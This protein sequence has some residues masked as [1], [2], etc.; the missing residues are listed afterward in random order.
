[1]HAYPNQISCDELY[2]DFIMG[3]GL[4][5][6][7]VHASAPKAGLRWSDDGG[8]TWSNQLY[9]DLGAI[10]VRTNRVTFANLGTT[11]PTG[12]IWEVECSSPAVRCMMYAAVR[13]DRLMV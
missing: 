9:R 8:N 13:G 2:L 5:S 6:S 4:N 7:D 3:V 10:G 12:R 11:Q 1:M